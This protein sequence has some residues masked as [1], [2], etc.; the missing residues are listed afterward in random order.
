MSLVAEEIATGRDL[1]WTDEELG[2]FKARLIEE[3]MKTLMDVQSLSERVAE[4]EAIG[5]DNGS[6]EGDLSDF[7]AMET[8]RRTAGL[9][10][11]RLQK[12][13]KKVDEAMLRIEE[14]TYGICVQCNCKINKDRLLAVPITTLSATYKI[15]NRCP[16]DG[17]D[18][19]VARR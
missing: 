10:I 15:T 8:E 6:G 4:I 9:E 1:S 3:R 16:I 11:V 5:C 14:G 12:Y 19:A 13:L 7:G 2:L 17:V 18:R